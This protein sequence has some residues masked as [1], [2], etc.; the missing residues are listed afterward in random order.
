MFY[1]GHVIWHRA[2]SLE[3]N[4]NHVLK[5]GVSMTTNTVARYARPAGVRPLSEA[6]DQL[7]RDAFTWP[8]MLGDSLGTSHNV[9]GGPGVNANLYETDESYILQMLIPACKIDDLT[10]TSQKNV[11]TVQG[12]AGVAAPEGARGLWVTLGGGE[13]HEQI[14]LP[15]DVESEKAAAAYQDG[16]LTL[17]LPKAEYT[18][19]KTIRI[20]STGGQQSAIESR[21]S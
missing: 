4:V 15:A 6:M 10:I 5:E 13:F 7:F 16:V 8:R 18:R 1:T 17:T 9:G 3:D 21:S 11:V 12:T 20:T 14:T 19:P 2:R